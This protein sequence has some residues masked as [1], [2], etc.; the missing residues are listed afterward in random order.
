MASFSQLKVEQ[1]INQAILY[2]WKMLDVLWIVYFLLLYISVQNNIND[3]NNA[4]KRVNI[5]QMSQVQKL[6]FLLSHIC[7]MTMNNHEWPCD[8]LI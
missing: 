1:L 5:S 8:S 6:Y 3:L 4:D 2:I 7:P